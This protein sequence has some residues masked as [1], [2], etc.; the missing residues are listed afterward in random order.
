MILYYN[1]KGIGD[2]LIVYFKEG[3]KQAV[4]TLGS[5]TRIYD[6]ATN[7]TLG[8]NLFNASTFLGTQESGQLKADDALIHLLNQ[9]IVRAGFDAILP[10]TC[11]PMIVTGYVKEMKK[12]P[13]SDHMHVCKVDLGDEELDIVCGAPNIDQGQKVVV[14]KIGALMPNG[15]LIRPT[16]LRGVASYGMICSARELALPNAPQKRG[17]L[18]LHS[19]TKIGQDFY[20]RAAHKMNA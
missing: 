17:I 13:D 14:A 19:E 5:V 16:M 12:H 10:E 7:E 15:T 1:R 11:E 6:A 3:E 18:V 20:E 4:Q 8:F 9:R 2:T